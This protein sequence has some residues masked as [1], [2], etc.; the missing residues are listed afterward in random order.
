MFCNYV[1]WSVCCN[2]FN[3]VLFWYFC[4]GVCLVSPV[5]R[6]LVTLLQFDLY[7]VYKGIRRRMFDI[8]ELF[9]LSQ[10]MFPSRRATH[11][12]RLC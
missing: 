5:D 6:V 12:S 1:F 3:S 7:D 10:S 2:Q 8:F 9:L 11:L 4:F